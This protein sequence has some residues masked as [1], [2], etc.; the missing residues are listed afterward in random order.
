LAA[1]GKLDQTADAVMAE[2]KKLRE[3]IAANDYQT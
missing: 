1:E 3:E 2:I